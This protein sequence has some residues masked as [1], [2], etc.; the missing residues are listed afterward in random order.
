MGK[1]LHKDFLK[2]FYLLKY[3][4]LV[5]AKIFWA[6]LCHIIINERTEKATYIEFEV[7]S[8]PY[9]VVEIALLKS[10]FFLNFN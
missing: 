7:G 2:D 6:S 5:V 1:I 8:I 9:Q 3:F 4:N 10:L